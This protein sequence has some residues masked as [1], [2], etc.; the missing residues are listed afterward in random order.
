MAS[1][2]SDYG[3]ETWLSAL[4]GVVALP[5]GYYIALCL[6][7]AGAAMDG[8][9]LADLEPTDTAYARQPY[10]TGVDEWGAN[11]PYL[12]NLL[13][14]E[15]PTPVEDWGYLTHFALCDSVTSGQLYAWGEM[16]NPQY[17]STDIGMLIPPGGLVLGLQALDNTIAA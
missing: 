5:T 3:A 14:I 2:V 16:F 1:G 6:D 11:G 10:G 15:F 9:M 4:F 13:D 17:V 7:E 8:D 12:T